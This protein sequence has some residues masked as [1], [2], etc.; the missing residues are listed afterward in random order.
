[1]PFQSPSWNNWY[2]RMYALSSG[3]VAFSSTPSR[4][5]TASSDD[6]A[7][8]SQSCFACRST[9]AERRRSPVSTMLTAS[10]MTWPFL[11]K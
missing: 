5:H 3:F 11:R 8:D 6:P 9:T 1:M 10:A 7:S 2:A 4:S